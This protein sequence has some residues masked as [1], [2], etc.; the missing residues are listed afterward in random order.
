MGWIQIHLFSLLLGFGLIDG[1]DSDKLISTL[2]DSDLF[3][4]FEFRLK[5]WIQEKLVFALTD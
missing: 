2:T 5:C 1:L 4:G 3:N